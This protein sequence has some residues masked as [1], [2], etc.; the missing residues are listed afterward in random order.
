MNATVRS[1]AAKRGIV[2]LFETGRSDAML[3]VAFN[4]ARHRGGNGNRL[5]FPS[6]TIAQAWRWHLRLRP[7][8][9]PD[10]N[11][12]PRLHLFRRTATADK[13]RRATAL[14]ASGRTT[15]PTEGP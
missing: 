14:P 10:G 12:F 2:R 9:Y 7:W 3:R 5:I 6:L 1:Q 11:P 8:C 15:P 4:N 13:A